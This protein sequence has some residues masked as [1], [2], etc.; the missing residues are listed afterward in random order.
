M[1]HTSNLRNNGENGFLLT[2]KRLMAAIILSLLLPVAA[3]AYTVVLRNGRNVEIP[4]SFTVT[5]AGITYQYAPGLYVTIQMTSIDITA[6]ER[7]NQE[8]A[9]ALLRRAENPADALEQSS[10]SIS[11]SAAAT[12]RTLTGKDLEASRARREA[13]E[14]LYERRRVELGLPSVEESRRQ[15][16]EEARRL[17]EI[18]NETGSSEAQQEAYWR[19]RAEEL[20]AAI[21]VTDAE[22]DYLRSKLRETNSYLPGIAFTTWTPFPFV[23]TVGGR[24][25]GR[26]FPS[27]PAGGVTGPR[28]GFPPRAPYSGRIAFGGGSTRGQVIFNGGSYR[29][30]ERRRVYNGPGIAVLPLPVYAPYSYNYSYDQS[31]LVQRLRELE[32]ERAGL[33]ARWRLLE[34]EARRAGAPPGWLRP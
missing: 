7:A 17:S 14:A 24:F 20:R 34:D 12:R 29:G 19:A 27:V 3:S 13:S 5:R 18:I 4:A 32:A 23:Q 10:A 26:S 21:A 2:H 11:S 22:I 1:L 8:P 9:G 16:E 25:P 6:T 31:M 30:Y 28:R 15:R 33:Q